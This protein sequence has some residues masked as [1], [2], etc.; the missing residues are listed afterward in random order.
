[1][2]DLVDYHSRVW[3]NPGILIHRLWVLIA[4]FTDFDKKMK[5]QKRRKKK[6]SR[7][8]KPVGKEEGCEQEDENRRD[9]GALMEAFGSVSVVEAASAYREAEEDL[10]KAA[11]ILGRLVLE[12]SDDQTATSSE[13]F[14]EANCGEDL[15]NEKG[16]KGVRRRRGWLQLQGLFQ[17]FWGRTM[18]CRSRP[19]RDLMKAKPVN[20]EEA[21]QFLCSMFGDECELSMAVVRD[22]LYLVSGAM[23]GS[24]SVVLVVTGQGQCGYNFDKIPVSWISPLL[25]VCS[26]VKISSWDQAS[27][28]LALDALLVLSDS[29][30]E[31][32][33]NSR[34][35]YSA[36][37]KRDTRFLCSDNGIV[38][39]TKHFLRG[40]YAEVLASSE[41]C[42]PSSPRI[43][44]L[45]PAQQVLEYLFNI[46]KSSEQEPS[47]MNWRNVAKKME[48]LGQGFD[49]HRSGV[50][51]PQPN[52]YAK[53]DEY[54]AYRKAANQ[55]WDSVKSC[56]Q[57]AATA[58][59]KGELTYA[60]Y[61]SDQGKVQTKVAREADEKASQNIFE[62]RNKSIKNVI[63]IDLHG[64]H[65]KQAIRLL[66]FISYL[67]YMCPGYHWMWVS[68]CGEVKAE[69]IGAMEASSHVWFLA[70]FKKAFKAYASWLDSGREEERVDIYIDGEDE[71]AVKYDDNSLEDPTMPCFIWVINLMEKEGIEWSEE[72]RGTVI[73]K[74]DGQR[75]F[76]FL[77]SDG[78]TE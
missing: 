68:W 1:M 49:F 44:Q 48:S 2:I 20:K 40:N 73:I 38:L 62:A 12:S 28:S 35:S 74:L 64:Q 36:K 57:K 3:G 22:V 42:S 43:S 37:S 78:E 21:E 41:T 70:V 59:S 31:P 13:G 9:A 16:F 77:E 54:Q 52:S 4:C 66:K 72:N 60:A 19:R 7:P 75:D 10:N 56:Y 11:E 76:R 34:C 46:P 24:Q 51:E 15:V 39:R 58:Y 26:L 8:R 6:G 71:K 65:V 18:L 33:M 63:T 5:P 50:V 14:V 32:S 30:H 61:L 27:A 29:L 47:T 25:L 23:L 17:R 55:Q 67:E 69:T 45:D 53:G